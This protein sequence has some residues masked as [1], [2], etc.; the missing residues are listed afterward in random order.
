VAHNRGVV[1]K[2]LIT[3]V[4]FVLAVVAILGTWIFLGHQLSLSLDGFRTLEIASVRIH[5]ITYEGSGT[6]GWFTV[7]DVH[8]S[9]NDTKIAVSIGSTKDNQFALATGGKVF[10]FGPIVS[11]AENGGEHLAVVPQPQDQALLVTRRSILSWPTP[12]DFN[13]MTG[14]SPAW[15]RHMYYQV[16]WKKPSGATLDMLWR[17]E[18]SFYGKQLLPATGWDSGFAIHEGSTGLVRVDIKE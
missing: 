16:V 15:K 9:L 1:R 6:G 17:Y 7:N 3:L 5:V 8:L 11:T 4:I 10:A 12:F 2:I 14:H 18:Q 13:F